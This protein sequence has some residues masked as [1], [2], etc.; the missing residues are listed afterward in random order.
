MR[1]Y[2]HANSADQACSCLVSR[3]PSVRSLFEMS[4]SG[5]AERVQQMPDELRGKDFPPAL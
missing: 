2:P 4:V 5:F 1:I 3:S